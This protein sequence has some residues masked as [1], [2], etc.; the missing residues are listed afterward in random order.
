MKNQ[1]PFAEYI[2]PH[3]TPALDN[4]ALNIGTPLVRV[5]AYEKVTGQTKY[6]ADYYSSNM[7]WAGVKRAGIPHARLKGVDTDL[8]SRVPGVVR[9]LTSR[10]ISGTN[11]Q[12]VIRRD[13]PVLVD[14]KV[15]HC[16]DAVALVLAE[17]KD[18]SQKILGSY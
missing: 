15:R 18:R 4:R 12:G 8:A 9:I 2:K 11:R 7:L 1:D 3:S 6:A 17:S 14:D 5:D 13:Q 10:D 16:G